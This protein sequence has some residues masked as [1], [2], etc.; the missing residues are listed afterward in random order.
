[1]RFPAFIKPR[2]G[3][4]WIGTGNGLI[5]YDG[6][7]F[8]RYTY[9]KDVLT[10]ISNSHVNVIL[11]DNQKQLWVGTNNGLNLFNKKE[12]NF[13]RIDV[14]KVKGGRNYI[15]SLIQDDNNTIWVGT[16]GGI[17]R[18]NKKKLL[19]EEISADLNSPFRKSRVL[20]LFFDRKYGVLVGTSKGL[21]CFDPKNGSRKNLPK[22]LSDN[23]SLLKSK[24]WK[25]D[26]GKKW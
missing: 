24:I 14:L 18:L 9:N 7:N 16:F 22:A 11:E 12:N 2:K 26:Q 17:K 4:I 15:S 5:S 20:S 8:S 13:L 6:Y 10:T 1:V 21:E 19:L 23:A 25:I 3:F